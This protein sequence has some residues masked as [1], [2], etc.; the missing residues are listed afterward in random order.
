VTASLERPEFVFGMDEGGNERMQLHR[1]DADGTVTEARWSFDQDVYVL[2]TGSGELT[3]LTPHEGDVRYLSAGWGPEGERFALPA[4]GRWRRQ[5]RETEYGSPEEDRE[6]LERISPINN[7]E[8]IEAYTRVV[9]FL[10]E[11]A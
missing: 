4:S 8:A 1:L 5:L 7:I 9:E 6:L 2:D 3:H 10:D 11:H